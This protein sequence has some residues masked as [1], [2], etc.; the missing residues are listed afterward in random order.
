MPTI[1]V[2]ILLSM[3]VHAI[4]LLMLGIVGPV[5]RVEQRLP[6]ESGAQFYVRLAQTDVA[7]LDQQNAPEN[8]GISALPAPKEFPPILRRAVQ[9]QVSVVNL[10]ADVPAE[11]FLPSSEIQRPAEL[12]LPFDADL[13][14]GA[15]GVIGRVHLELKIDR[16][17]KVRDARVIDSVDP[18]KTM[19]K[20]IVSWLKSSPFQPGRKDGVPVNSLLQV[21]L[22]LSPPD[23]G[24][25]N[26]RATRS[27]GQPLWM[28]DKGKFI[29]DAPAALAR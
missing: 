4:S 15:T 14:P 8:T 12:L 17:G 3:A 22:T 28:D 9:S 2:A 21:D 23:R 11:T 16:H 19:E 13:I 29:N 26:F 20:V 6:K 7:V 10:Q 25:P 18:G 5:G 1:S 27:P 24:D